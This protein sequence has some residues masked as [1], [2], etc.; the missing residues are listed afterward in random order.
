MAN[1]SFPGRRSL[2]GKAGDRSYGHR[3][4]P[5]GVRH[6][7]HG[8][9]G[10]VARSECGSVDPGILLPGQGT[11]PA[12]FNTFPFRE[13]NHHV[14][15]GAT[16]DRAPT[17]SGRRSHNARPS[18]RPASD[19]DPIGRPAAESDAEIRRPSPGAFRL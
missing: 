6:G 10:S 16:P 13:S 1:S 3:L 17:I 5:R 12:A 8:H 19:A 2:P 9:G 7:L 4:Y 18:A 11:A 15:E 14:P